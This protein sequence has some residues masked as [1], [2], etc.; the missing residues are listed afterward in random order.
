MQVVRAHCGA[1]VVCARLLASVSLFK[2]H[3]I[4][5]SQQHFVNKDVHMLW[6]KQ[7]DAGLQALGEAMECGFD[8]YKVGLVPLLRLLF[9]ICFRLHFI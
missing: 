3:F 6:R 2:T 4:M 1:R 7:V 8:D 5:K 9:M